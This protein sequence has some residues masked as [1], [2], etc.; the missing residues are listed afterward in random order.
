M[1]ISLWKDDVPEDSRDEGFEEE[2]AGVA[3][4]I[5]FSLANRESKGV[6][7]VASDI[8]H[9]SGKAGH[10]LFQLFDAIHPG[11]PADQAYKI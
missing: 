7:D 3:I 6:F 2:I 4:I 11:R 1:I 5:F 9:E 10:E 8:V